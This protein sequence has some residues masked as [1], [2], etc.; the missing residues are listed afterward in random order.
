MDLTIKATFVDRVHLMHS[1]QAVTYSSV[2]SRDL[3]TI[4]LT[5]AALNDLDICV[6]NIHSAY[7]NSDTDEKVNFKTGLELLS[8]LGGWS[9]V[10]LRDLYGLNSS[11]A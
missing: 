10:I 5:I 4:I 3:V 9:A 2:V 11:R 8:E 1:P 6:F 7:L